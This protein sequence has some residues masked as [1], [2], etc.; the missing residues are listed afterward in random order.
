MD[1]APH[2]IWRFAVL[3]WLGLIAGP[4]AHA[5]VRWQMGVGRDPDMS[6]V[7][8][9]VFTFLIV[10]AAPM[11]ALAFGVFASLALAIDTAIHGR[12][13]RLVNV[14]LGALLSMPAL[15]VVVLVAGWPM[16]G[17]A[18]HAKVLVATLMLAGMIVGLGLRYRGD[19]QPVRL[20]DLS[21]VRGR[22]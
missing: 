20:R 6:G 4:T 15:V 16:R 7:H 1:A 17:S 5:V 18:P 19:S 21:I 12:T 2:R 13:P 9:L 8:E 11:A 14:L 22:E 10:L 3:A